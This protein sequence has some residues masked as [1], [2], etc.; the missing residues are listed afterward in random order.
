MGQKY[1]TLEERP[2]LLYDQHGDIL[3]IR[4]SARKIAR[5]I[6]SSPLLYF[7]YLHVIFETTPEHEEI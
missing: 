5:E 6:T 2:N 7:L 4:E 3:V 1:T